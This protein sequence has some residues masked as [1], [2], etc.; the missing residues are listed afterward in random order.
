MSILNECQTH[1]SET[2]T[3]QSNKQSLKKD[4]GLNQIQDN[5]IPTNIRT[6]QSPQ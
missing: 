5:N 4:N 1:T 2:G 3:A 6:R